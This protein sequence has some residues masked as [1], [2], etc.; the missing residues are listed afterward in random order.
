M[1]LRLP[2]TLAQPLELALP[3]ALEPLEELPLAEPPLPAAPL[4]ELLGLLETHWEGAAPLP[5]GLP[6]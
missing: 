2:L 5:L 6:L 1:A 3:L 4:G